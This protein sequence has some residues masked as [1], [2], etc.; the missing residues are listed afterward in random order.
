MLLLL[1]LLRLLLRLLLLLLPLLVMGRYTRPN[2][3]RLSRTSLL[4]GL[5]LGTS[6]RW[7]ER[8]AGRC[9][10]LRWPVRSL[11]LHGHNNLLIQRLVSR[12]HTVSHNLR[13]QLAHLRLIENGAPVGSGSQSE[14]LRVTGIFLHALL[15]HRVDGSLQCVEVLLALGPSLG[16]RPRRGP[17]WLLRT[18]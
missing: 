13:P 18:G 5:R 1:L 14:Q 7:L 8:T 16:T 11:S 3:L 4:S 6:W 17:G 9:G 10:A 2:A 12:Q 15:L